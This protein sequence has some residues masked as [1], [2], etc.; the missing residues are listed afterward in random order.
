MLP[1]TSDRGAITAEFAIVLPTVFL[2][3]AFSMSTLTAQFERTR[4]V[5]VA[6]GLA[7]AVARGEPESQVR[8]LYATQLR[9][10]TVTFSTEGLL[11][12]AEVGRD[13]NLLGL[14]NLPLRLADRECSRRLGL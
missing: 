5:S 4:L 14:P 10:S 9:G 6:A 1:A 7:R 8:E 11:L 2:L 12:C 3:L 13:V